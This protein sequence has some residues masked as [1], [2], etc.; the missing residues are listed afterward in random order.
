MSKMM[1]KDL[2][3]SKELSRESMATVRGGSWGYGHGYGRGYGYG[4]DLFSFGDVKVNTDQ[5]NAQDQNIASVAGQNA[6]SLGGYFDAYSDVYAD[7]YAHNDSNVN[8]GQ[9]N[10]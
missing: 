5:L 2:T 10:G 6:A 7:Q 3:E 4:L 9:N 8:I 1:I